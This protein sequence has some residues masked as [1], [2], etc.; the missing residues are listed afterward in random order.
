M[1]SF[2]DEYKPTS[3]KKHRNMHLLFVAFDNKEAFDKIVAVKETSLGM[4]SDYILKKNHFI[5]KVNSCVF[6]KAHN[7][8]FSMN[9]YELRK[10][11]GALVKAYI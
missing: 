5:K 8:F 6:L 9:S 4:Y 3:V 10:L 7:A 1:Q 2:L 11:S